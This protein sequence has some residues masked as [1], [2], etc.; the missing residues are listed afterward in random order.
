[1]SQL[2]NTT[3]LL[4]EDNQPYREYLRMLLNEFGYTKVIEASDGQ[5]ALDKLNSEGADLVIADYMMEPVT[6]MGLLRLMRQS[7]QHHNIPFIMI[8]ANND[9]ATVAQADRYGVT[10]YLTKPL[11][12]NTF[13]KCVSEAN[14]A[15][16]MRLLMQ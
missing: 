4:V 16:T 8:T 6:G 5:E 14:L 1:M 9:Q 3:I 11:H 10:W 15:D 2:A 12:V 7:V 13:E